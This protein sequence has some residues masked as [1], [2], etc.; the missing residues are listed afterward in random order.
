[1]DR[2]RG[3][4]VAYAPLIFWIGVIF[5]LS[6]DQGS[7]SQ[8]SLFVRPLLEF[9]F[10]TAPEETL[11]IY[12]G[13]VRKG[14]HFT[15]YAVLA[16]LAIRACSMSSLDVVRRTRHLLPLILVAFVAAIDELNQSFEA[17][18]TGSV[19]DAL[20]DIF[21]GVVIIAG[22]WAIKRPRQLPPAQPPADGRG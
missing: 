21:G 16:F 6:S 3:A 15:E 8:T 20:L 18:R 17:S 22:M 4:I 10:P 11:Q 19:G 1:M 7:M 9:L 12:H 5:F 14:A 2:W 13:Y